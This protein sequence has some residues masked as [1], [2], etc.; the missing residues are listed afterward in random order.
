MAAALLLA[1]AFVAGGAAGCH[2]DKAHRPAHRKGPAPTVGGAIG[3]DPAPPPPAPPPPP[4]RPVAVAAP[5]PPP[6]PA[7]PPPPPRP[8]ARPVAERKPAPKR[9]SPCEGSGKGASYDVWGVEASDVLNV[10]AQP[11]ASASVL[12]ELA[13]DTTGVSL[14][15]DKSGSWRKIECGKVVGWVNGKFLARAK[16]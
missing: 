16:D 14:T 11:S 2:D 6:R 5:P 10:R 15:G 9:G 7:P 4:P 1:A 3:D 12:G 8:A 13:P